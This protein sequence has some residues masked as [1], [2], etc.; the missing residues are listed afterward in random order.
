MA[1]RSGKQGTKRAQDE[2][3]IARNAKVNQRF[4]I[5]E[6]LEAGLVLSGSEV[7][8]LRAGKVDLDGAFARIANGEVF[9]HGMYIAPY[10]PA[11]AFGHDPRRTRKLLLHAREI[12][13]WSGRVTARG[14]TIVPIRVYLKKGWAKVELGLAKGKKVRDDREKLRREAEMKEAR[15]VMR[16][17]KSGR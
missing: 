15:A 8:S 9:L 6:R 1:A 11:R 12:E 5:E 16:A 4:E 7:K 17:A 13:R 10:E 2:I 14:Y 3:P